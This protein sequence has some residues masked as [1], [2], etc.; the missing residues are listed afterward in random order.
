MWLVRVVGLSVVTPGLC[1]GHAV[2]VR[3]R[4]P[5]QLLPGLGHGDQVTA[6]AFLPLVE[7]TR[8]GGERRSLTHYIVSYPHYKLLK[9]IVPYSKV[10]LNYIHV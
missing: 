2:V 6:S 9:E 10:S 1:R 7:G 4:R 5:P 8:G 3:A